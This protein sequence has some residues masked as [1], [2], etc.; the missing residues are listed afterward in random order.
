[1]CIVD[2]EIKTVEV[3]Q[4]VNEQGTE[5][6]AF[7]TE[8]YPNQG[9]ILLDGVERPSQDPNFVVSGKCKD[10]ILVIEAKEYGLENSY[11]S[12]TFLIQL[13]PGWK[14]QSGT[15]PILAV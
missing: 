7:S 10:G 15:G 1:M 3:I 2:S 13:D 5:Q 12:S 8:P 4:T 9:S 11:L 14:R 6:I